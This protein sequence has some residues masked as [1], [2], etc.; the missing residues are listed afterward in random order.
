MNYSAF[1]P[2]RRRLALAAAFALLGP[3]ASVSAQPAAYPSK[4]LTFVV[5]FA[6]GS[7]T[8]Q[9][10]RA[11]G[12]AITTDTKQAVVVDNKAGASGMIA[13]QAVAKAPADGYTVL[14]T[15]NTTH[16]ANEHL[17]RKLPY[18]PVKDFVP[19]TGL[20]KGGQ[21][22]VV[23]AGAPY[24]SVA[25]LL[26]AAKK[27]PGKLSFG[28]GS[29]SS[30]MAGEML[31]QLAGVDIL[32]VPYKSNP[33][34]ITDLLGG[35]IDMMITDTSTGVPQ[36]KSGKLRALG[37][38][39]Q[40]RSAQLPDVPTLEEAGVKGYDMGYWF[41]AYV[42]AGT[43]APVVSRLNELLTAAT[44]S[45]AA[46]SFYET[47]GSEPWTTTSAE[48]ARFQAAETQKWGKVIKAAGIDPE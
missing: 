6:A 39:T 10:A 44:Q 32:H 20:G 35:Q 2:S 36:V 19:V 12:Q 30:R 13:A 37:Y 43:P 21:V 34:A 29:S 4:P 17:Y 14:I 42:P 28:S 31:K 48:L 38:S 33:L 7:A 18:D 25:D 8:D 11:L 41:A 24:R 23:N 3:A 46:K 1:R 5:P 15:T 9:L 26:A 22:L 27:N 47:A 45:A 16:A 40:K